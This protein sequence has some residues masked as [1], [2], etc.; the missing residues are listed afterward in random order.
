MVFLT[1]KGMPVD[2]R[3][4]R[5]HFHLLARKLEL[6][7]VKPHSLRHIASTTDNRVGDDP[8]TRM[9]QRGRVSME[10]ECA[11]YIHPDLRDQHAAASLRALF[12]VGIAE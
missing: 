8:N 6:P 11:V 10:S 3:T 7:R 12:E 2:A 1:E 5:K 4:W 9:L